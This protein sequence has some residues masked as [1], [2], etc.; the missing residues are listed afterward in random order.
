MK[1]KYCKSILEIIGKAKKNRDWSISDY[2]L[3]LKFFYKKLKNEE[4]KEFK[5]SILKLLQGKVYIDNLIDICRDL[6]IKESCTLLLKLFV[7]PPRGLKE[8]NYSVWMEGLQRNIVYTL[9][10]LKC[11]DAVTILKKLI[12][13]KDNV[14]KAPLFNLKW[15]SCGVAIHALTNISPEESGRYFGWWINVIQKI[16]NK[17][18]AFATSLADWKKMEKNMLAHVIDTDVYGFLSVKNCIISVAQNNGMLGFKKWLS[19]ITLYNRKD[20][21]FLLGQIQI[22]ADGKNTLF[23]NLKKICNY[24]GKSGVFAK[25]LSMLPKIENKEEFNN[26]E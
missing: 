4:K 25:E 2:V 15:G 23:P 19:S 12:E 18:L 21:E 26:S 5:S 1:N 24:R 11:K 14:T 10:I 22:L 6:K 9:G 16:E 13:N 17:Q 20:R 8:N 3:P 7:N